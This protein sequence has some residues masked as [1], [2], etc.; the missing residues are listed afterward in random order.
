MNKP[1]FISFHGTIAPTGPKSRFYRGFIVTFRHTTI[2]RAPLGK[3]SGRRKDLLLCLTTHN[4]QKRQT[5]MSPARFEPA[6]L[7]SE[8][9]QTHVLDSAFD[10]LGCPNEQKIKSYVSLH[11]QL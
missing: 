1:T 7:A 9:S 6:I 2:G 5:S 8:R 3:W 4:T 11:V 10:G